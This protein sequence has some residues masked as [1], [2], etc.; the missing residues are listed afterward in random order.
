MPYYREFGYKV[1]DLPS[2]ENYYNNCITIP[3][4]PTLSEDEQNFVIKTI[5]DFY[6]E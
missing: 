4:Y 1:G 6:N 2:A 5:N 3:M